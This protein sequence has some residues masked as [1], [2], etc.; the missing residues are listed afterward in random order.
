MAALTLFGNQAVFRILAPGSIDFR[1]EDVLRVRRGS[2]SI[3][4]RAS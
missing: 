2:R 4:A 1:A 3:E